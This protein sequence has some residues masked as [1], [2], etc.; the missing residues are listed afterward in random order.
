MTQGEKKKAET[1]QVKGDGGQT[2]DPNNPKGGNRGVILP[3]KA[4]GDPQKEDS[5]SAA[6]TGVTR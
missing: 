3:G 4:E 2:D 6:P 1:T 5:G